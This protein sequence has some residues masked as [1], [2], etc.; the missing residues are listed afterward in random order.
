M[1]FVTCD[2]LKEQEE[3]MGL[4][5]LCHTTLSVTLTGLGFLWCIVSFKQIHQ[6][7][8]FT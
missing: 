3:K 7:T 6:N 8:C 4:K 1:E 2:I 5:N